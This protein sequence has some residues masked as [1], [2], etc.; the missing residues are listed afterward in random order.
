MVEGI[1]KLNPGLLS[2]L[3]RHEQMTPA[4]FDR[5]V[6]QESGLLGISET[7]SDMRDLLARE[8]VELF[9]YQTKK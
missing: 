5:M 3:S 6:N 9:C 7:S 4:Q 1:D 8:A 2:F